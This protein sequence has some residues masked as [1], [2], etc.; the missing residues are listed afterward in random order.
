[1]RRT[2]RSGS[3][4]GSGRKRM[5]W[6]KLK[7]AVFAPMPSASV[8]TATSVNAGC[9]NRIRAPYR[10]SWNNVFIFFTFNRSNKSY[11]TY[12]SFVTQRNHWIDFRRA[13]CGQVTRQKRNQ[14]QQ[15]GN[16]TKRQRIPRRH[17]V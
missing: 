1:M 3:R 17:T 2:T 10:R 16:E 4:N 13:S 8:A 15:Q 7:I 14:Q 11:R 6:T 5:L 9:F 12:K